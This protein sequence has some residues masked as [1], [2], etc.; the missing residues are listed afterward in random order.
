MGVMTL[1]ANT[2]SKILS[3]HL[4]QLGGFLM[5]AI[6]FLLDPGAPLYALWIA[7]VLD[8]ISRIFAEAKKHGGLGKAVKQG[9]IRSHA[10]FQ[11]T[12]VKIVAYF[13]MCIMAAQAQHVFGY[14]AAAQCFASVVYSILFLVEVGSMGENFREAGVSSFAWISLFSK[15]K[16][17]TLCDGSLPAEEPSPDSSERSHHHETV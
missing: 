1:F 3:N 4:A 11:G 2:Y 13:F 10:I 16:L 15:K 12:A 7:V 17:E 6:C 8:L 9:H 5:G 14:Q